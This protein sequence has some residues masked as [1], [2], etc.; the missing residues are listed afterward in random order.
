MDGAPGARTSAATWAERAQ[1]AA[2]SVNAGFGHRLF[3]LVPGTWI[4][5]TSRPAPRGGGPWHYWWQAHYLDCLVDASWRR[6]GD[7]ASQGRDPG[8]GVGEPR[9]LALARR[10]LRTIRL[11]KA[12][13]L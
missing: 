9:E 6:L 3:G 5:R 10:L 2:D 7:P 4:A 11:R 1:A 13:R 8:W 12:L